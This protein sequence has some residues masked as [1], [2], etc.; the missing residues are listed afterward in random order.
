[1]LESACIRRPGLVDGSFDV[2]RILETMLYYDKVNLFVDLP[3]FT[4]LWRKF[5]FAGT[6][7]LLSHPSIVS[8]IT[9]EFSGVQNSS[10]GA[11]RV[12]TPIF[13]RYSGRDGK[14]I[15]DNDYASSLFG[16]VARQPQ[17]SSKRQVEKI[18]KLTKRME[19]EEFLGKDFSQNDIFYSI[20]SD[21]ESFRIFVE[22]YAKRSKLAIDSQRLEK[23]ETEAFRIG[24]GFILNS[25]IQPNDILISPPP[26][27]TTSHNWEVVLAAVHDYAIDLQ[28]T[29][30]F[31]VDLVCSEDVGEVADRRIDLGIRR[32]L[33]SSDAISAFERATIGRA[34]AFAEA[35]NSGQLSLSDALRV[36]D[37]TRKFREW[38]TGLPPAAD[39]LASY[40]QEI[41]KDPVLEKLPVKVARFSLFTGVGLAIDALSGG[42][43]VGTLIGTGLSACDAFL[44]DH[45][46]SGWRPSSFVKTVAQ[47][48]E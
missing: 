4:G 44:V 3:V 32:G 38:L 25:N 43:G 30:K 7:D 18:L 16:M 29:G 17:Y 35:V 28:L 2:G 5:G 47:A 1:M 10:D 11:I 13:G 6:R 37:R 36:V 46:G 21:S 48:L 14:V 45:I 20:I 33:R 31:S 15:R 22:H 39:L 12:H 24:G 40:H 42:S 8:T 26:E 23:L 19:Y 41:A 9:T 34:H 27:G